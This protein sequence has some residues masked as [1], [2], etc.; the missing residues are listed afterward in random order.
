MNPDHAANG[1]G[2]MNISGAYEE[3]MCAWLYCM[4]GQGKQDVAE[5]IKF[6]LFLS[7]NFKKPRTMTVI[8]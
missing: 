1:V 8:Q 2:D 6:D 5:N 3:V 7:I 4:L